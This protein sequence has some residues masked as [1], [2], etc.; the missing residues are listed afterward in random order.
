M[1][2]FD[3]LNNAE[4]VEETSGTFELIKPGRYHLEV[5]ACEERVSSGGKDYISLRSVIHGPSYTGRQLFC[6]FW[7]S[8][9]KIAGISLS[10]LR[11]IANNDS[12]VIGDV[13]GKHYVADIYIE[14]GQAKP[15]GSGNWPDKNRQR[16][17]APYEGQ[18][19]APA[20]KADTTGTA[21]G[22]DTF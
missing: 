2:A 4:A 19:L 6:D 12:G 10:Q 11:K 14:K 9:P 21:D 15:D 8:T 13:T 20:P 16:N 1:G 5:V 7:T 22:W 17:F 3:I 18:D